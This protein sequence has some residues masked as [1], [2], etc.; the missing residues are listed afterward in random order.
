MFFRYLLFR[1][2]F[3]RFQTLERIET[4]RLC[5]SKRK[6]MCEQRQT[7]V[8]NYFFC[9]SFC[10]FHFAPRLHYVNIL[11]PNFSIKSKKV[12]VSLVL[13]HL[14]TSTFIESDSRMNM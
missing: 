4:V 3:F 12:N 10:L 13:Q 7:M 9:S 2:S 11:I 1:F 6:K 8:V 5:Y 14:Y